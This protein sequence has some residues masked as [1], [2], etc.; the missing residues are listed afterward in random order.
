MRKIMLRENGFEAYSPREK[1][2]QIQKTLHA[3]RIQER[4]ANGRARKENHAKKIFS[5][6]RG[7]TKSAPS[8]RGKGGKREN[9]KI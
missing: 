9:L 5:K 7:N 8:R 4:R 6:P 1:E 2:E 3:K